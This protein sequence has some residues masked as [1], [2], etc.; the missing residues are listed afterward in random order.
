MDDPCFGIEGGLVEFVGGGRVEGCAW[1]GEV[2][3]VEDLRNEGR[4]GGAGK[5]VIEYDGI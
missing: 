5:E 1:Q 4:K 3:G 2:L